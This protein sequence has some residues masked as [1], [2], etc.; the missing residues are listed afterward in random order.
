[1]LE[2]LVAPLGPG[3]EIGTN[4]AAAAA[5]AGTDAPLVAWRY[6]GAGLS[7]SDGT[8]RAK[9]TNRAPGPGAMEL[10]LE[11]A[12]RPGAHADAGWSSRRAP[13]RPKRRWAQW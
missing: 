11:G 4:L 7:T 13:C 12:P 10:F 5:A 3:I 9:R 1:V 6:L 8:Y 2:Q